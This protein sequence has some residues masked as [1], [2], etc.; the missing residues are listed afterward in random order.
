MAQVTQIQRKVVVRVSPPPLLRVRVRDYGLAVVDRG[1]IVTV[2]ERPITVGVHKS[3]IVV[4]VKPPALRVRFI[5]AQG[6]AGRPGEPGAAIYA[7]V[8]FEAGAAI[9]GHR[10]VS[11]VDGVLQY[12]DNRNIDDAS[13]LE[14]ISTNAAVLGGTVNVRVAG[15]ITNTGTWFWTP[16]LP[17]YLGQDGN[18]TQTPPQAP[19]VFSIEVGNALAPDTIDVRIGPPILL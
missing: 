15:I 16:G 5:A 17:V 12:A 10:A 19:A 18:L 8:A 3:P 4:A 6:P 11:L 13:L 14:G 9:S 7:T 2:S 1:G